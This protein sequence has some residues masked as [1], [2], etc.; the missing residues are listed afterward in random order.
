MKSSPMLIK[1]QDSICTEFEDESNTNSPNKKL[2]FGNTPMSRKNAMSRFAGF[3]AT[4][5]PKGGNF[6]NTQMTRA[7]SYG[8]DKKI[9]GR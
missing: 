2:A 1:H 3:G 6:M 5:T 4:A 7:L 8:S 9:G